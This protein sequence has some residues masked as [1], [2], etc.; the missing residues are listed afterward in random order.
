MMLISRLV[1]PNL[2]V[3]LAE[4]RGHHAVL[5]HAVQDAV[6]ADD[7]GVYGAGQ[8]Q[9]ANQN[10]ER[11]EEQANPLRADQEHGQ[12]ADQVV[13]DICRAPSRG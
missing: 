7:S 10:D 12:A 11:V 6:G 4:P 5:S 1:V 13:E 2:L 8:N 3:R 9:R